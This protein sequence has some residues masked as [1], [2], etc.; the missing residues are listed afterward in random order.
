MGN[1]VISF[2]KNKPIVPYLLIASALIAI[3]TLVFLLPPASKK[4]VVQ[5][6]LFTQAE[7][8]GYGYKTANLLELQETLKSVSLRDSITVN[9]PEFIGISHPDIITLFHS[10][11]I[12]LQEEW[13]LL[14][15]KHFSSKSVQQKILATKTLPSPF[16]NDLKKL[17]TTIY[18]LSKKSPIILP[19]PLKNF[20]ATS[21]HA[22]W[23]LMVRSTG[24][25]DTDQLSN[26]GG[27]YTQ[28]NV[29]PDEKEVTQALCSVIA[30]YFS[31]KSFLQ[32]LQAGDTSL[33][34]IPLAPVLI[35]RMIGERPNSKPE[36]IPV[37][38]VAYSQE[39]S[40]QTPGI[41]TIQCAFGHNEGVVESSVPSDTFY[42]TNKQFIYQIIKNKTKR[43]IPNQTKA[44]LTFTDNPKI[45]HKKPTLDRKAIL[46]IDSVVR[47][48]ENHYQKPMDLELVYDPS[49]KKIYVV[50]A[51]PIVY[52][53]KSA[54]PNYLAAN[55]DPEN[56]F[57][58]TT[59]CTGDNNVQKII[60]KRTI[61]L[62]QTLNQA[63]DRYNAMGSEKKTIQTVVIERNGQ[64]TSHAAAIFRGEGI[65]VVQTNNLQVLDTWLNNANKHI[66][67]DAQRQIILQTNKDLKL[68]SGFFNHPVAAQ[69]SLD[70]SLIN[71]PLPTPTEKETPFS[72]QELVTT[73]KEKNHS[74]VIQAA[75]RLI[76]KLG[77]QLA[78][79]KQSII[80]Y[81]HEENTYLA[82]QATNTASIL[83]NITANIAAITPHLTTAAGKHNLMQQL[84]HARF[85]EALL[86]Q[87]P[88]A[89]TVDNYSVE[90][91]LNEHNNTIIFYQN[92]LQPLIKKGK[93]SSTL[94]NN[95]LLLELGYQGSRVAL[96]EKITYKWLRFID[97]LNTHASHYDHVKLN[98]MIVQITNA[99]LFS[100]WLNGSFLQTYDHFNSSAIRQRSLKCLNA[101]AEEFL[102]AQKLIATFSQQQTYLANILTQLWESP[103]TVKQQLNDFYLNILSFF[104]SKEFTSL[105]S[106]SKTHNTILHKICLATMLLDA[107][108]HFDSLIKAIKG[109][110]QFSNEAEKITIIRQ[111]LRYYFDLL[112][113][114]TPSPQLT[115]AIKR[116][117]DSAPKT[118]DQLSTSRNFNVGD[119]VFFETHYKEH[120]KTDQNKVNGLIKT[121]EDSFTATHQLLLHKISTYVAKKWQ[122]QDL[123]AK[124]ILVSQAEQYLGLSKLLTGISVEKDSIT[125]VYHKKL[126]AHSVGITLRYAMTK[127]NLTITTQFYG[128]NE[129]ARWNM[130]SDYISTVAKL[131]N[132]NLVHLE[133]F[134][135][136]LTYSWDCTD[137]KSLPIINTCLQNSIATTFSLGI[138]NA[139]KMITK[140][141]KIL[142]KL[143]NHTIQLA[144]GADQ[145]MN[146]LVTSRSSQQNLL[147]IPLISKFDQKNKDQKKSL[148][149][150]LQAAQE[151]LVTNKSDMIPLSLY[152]YK[153]AAP[154][155]NKNGMISDK[156][157]ASIWDNY[158]E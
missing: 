150:L 91:I 73:L 37:G 121:L 144:G 17:R 20:I 7:T 104:H 9:V 27:N 61:I 41:T 18:S 50:Q 36:Q 39:P 122:L 28:A 107:I 49:V 79:I 46:A 51:R 56:S 72:F 131:M 142:E 23:K 64:T 96:S 124:P 148:A 101:L 1:P 132:L 114:F 156:K 68:T 45:L 5:K 129:Y 38:C 67:L 84:F 140:T 97:A 113:E 80:T 47:A 123:L 93:L 126:R 33:F 40:A 120:A 133:H 134:K 125:Y 138:E 152:T 146:Q 52:S 153:Q 81:H 78:R 82:T 43:L 92:T 155:F 116:I 118:I 21:A 25:E 145:L 10:H 19:Q 117:L 3:A 16:L 135:T 110:T 151:N 112:Q 42:V 136:G 89:E 24:K 127:P 59:I 108:E 34:D 63:L 60:S 137:K 130:I 13:K 95:Q 94:L 90:K 103:K 2:K 86:F 66:Y 57:T 31:K 76:N 77:A 48:V 11:G 100:S 143:T 4:N 111:A 29:I 12:D 115:I 35:Q 58:C 44:I 154:I 158:S 70:E 6:N 55:P 62:A 26:A 69:V 54:K 149:H 128:D 119:I 75:N 74:S 53:S 106:K 14:Q 102:S 157:L 85:I 141:N 147:L 22:S 83:Q 105:L 99:N 109:S 71:N 32:R 15:K 98:D 65:L 88:T 87:Q 30:S 8:H 139:E